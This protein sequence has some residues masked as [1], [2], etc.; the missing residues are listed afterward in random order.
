MKTKSF[1]SAAAFL[2]C[3]VPG[4]TW[5]QIAIDPI[6]Q[7]TIETHAHSEE[8]NASLGGGSMDMIEMATRARNKGMRAIVVKPMYF[9]TATRAYLA[10]KAV[11]GIEVYGGI[12]LNRSLGGMNAAAVDGFA[13]LAAIIRQLEATSC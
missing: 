5:A 12:T 10:T 4:G 6:L 1:A 3:V 7:G 13:L 11:P 2:L 8:D 9:E